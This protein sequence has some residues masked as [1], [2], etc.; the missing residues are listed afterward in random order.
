MYF[1]SENMSF[2]WIMQISDIN[3][4]KNRCRRNRGDSWRNRPKKGK[5]EATFHVLADSAATT[6][7]RLMRIR[8]PLRQET[9]WRTCIPKQN[10]LNR[11]Q[12]DR[13][14]KESPCFLIIS[15]PYSFHFIHK[16]RHTSRSK[17]IFIPH[18]SVASAFISFKSLR[19]AQIRLIR[20]IMLILLHIM[21]PFSWLLSFQFSF[22][23]L[24]FFAT[25]RHHT[26]TNTTQNLSKDTFYFSGMVVYYWFE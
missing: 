1:L 14:R 25:P 2:L 23:F 7:K 26:I 22:S 12:H 15:I 5:K 17:Q 11:S 16:N 6:R 24:L 10:K 19:P 21:H 3:L 9:T 4:E 20:N 18:F 8:T 13:I